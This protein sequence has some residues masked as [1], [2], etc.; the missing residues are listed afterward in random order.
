VLVSAAAV[1]MEVP[2]MFDLT[3]EEMAL[4]FKD[5]VQAIQ[6]QVSI[7]ETMFVINRQ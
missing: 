3:L 1:V 6:D 4:T 7:V 5:I 2:M